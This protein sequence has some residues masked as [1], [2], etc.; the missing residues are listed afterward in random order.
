MVKTYNNR[1]SGSLLR[2][3][4]IAALITIGG[5]GGTAYGTKIPERYLTITVDQVFHVGQ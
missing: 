2:R 3:I 4:S 1:P 5:R